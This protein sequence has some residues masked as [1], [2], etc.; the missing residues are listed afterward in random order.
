MHTSTGLDTGLRFPGQVH[1]WESEL[2]QN[3]MRDYDP[4]TGQYI[5]GDP[6]GLVDGASVYGY[7]TQ[8][9]LRFID[10]KGEFGVIGAAIGA[11]SNF[12]IQTA[13]NLYMYD[14]D[15]EKSLKCVNFSDVILSGAFGAVGASPVSVYKATRKAKRASGVVAITT[16]TK[17][18]L[19]PVPL[20]IE[21]DCYCKSDKRSPLSDLISA[22]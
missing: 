9:P 18:I 20:R 12:A 6:L 5:Q 1:H 19:A 4:T 7:V 3:W 13:V 2:H 22:M 15:L 21:D 10:P 17:K 16:Y 8:S 11:I 14:V